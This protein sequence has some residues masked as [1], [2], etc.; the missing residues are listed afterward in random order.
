MRFCE[1]TVKLLKAR[2]PR[3]GTGPGEE[4]HPLQVG[5]LAASLEARALGAECAACSLAAPPLPGLH[6]GEI[7]WMRMKTALI[8]QVCSGSGKQPKRP[9][10]GNWLVKY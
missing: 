2:P 1:T 6:P 10:I 3:G 4:A 5:G 8:Q 9:V 7:S